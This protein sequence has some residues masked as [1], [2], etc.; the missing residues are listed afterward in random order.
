MHLRL[1]VL[2]QHEESPLLLAAQEG[3]MDVVKWLLDDIGLDINYRN[4][5]WP[6]VVLFIAVSCCKGTCVAPLFA[7]GPV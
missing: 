3:N 1:H 4:E 6:C 5:V 2:L 7:C